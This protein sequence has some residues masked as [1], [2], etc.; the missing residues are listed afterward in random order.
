MRA[1]EVSGLAV[2]LT[3]GSLALVLGYF[4]FWAEK[5]VHHET[6]SAAT[7]LERKEKEPWTQARPSPKHSAARPW[8]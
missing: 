6:Q 1:L 3:A 4:L 5:A 2:T 8:T 7:P